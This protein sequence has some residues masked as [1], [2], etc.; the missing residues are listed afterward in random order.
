MKEVVGLYGKTFHTWQIDRDA[1][2][3]MGMPR[4]MGS[5]T[6]Y[7]QLDIDEAL[8][9]R[10]RRLKVDHRRKRDVREGIQGPGV[11]ENADSWWKEAQAQ[12]KGVYSC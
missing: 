3:P 4:L 7:K 2:V 1:D 9:D 8:E 6:E 10:N 5:L 11:H 12:G